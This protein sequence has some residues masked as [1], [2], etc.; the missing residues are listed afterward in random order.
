MTVRSTDL[1]GRDTSI[2]SK[3]YN[4]NFKSQAIIHKHILPKGRNNP[5]EQP[6]D[7]TTVRMDYHPI[8]LLSDPLVL[9]IVLRVTYRY[10]INLFRLTLL[11]S[12][13]FN[14][15]IAGLLRTIICMDYSGDHVLRT[16]LGS[17]PAVIGID[18]FMSITNMLRFTQCA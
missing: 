6:S 14:P 5:L 15:S 17:Q 2:F 18:R 16:A 11:S 4:K 1:K 3:C 8:E 13:P 9:C 7:R 12:A 10:A